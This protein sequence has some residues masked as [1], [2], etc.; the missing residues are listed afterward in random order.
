MFT[1]LK[2]EGDI[3]VVWSRVF[4]HSEISSTKDGSLILVA[5]TT[6]IVFPKLI[7]VFDID[8]HTVLR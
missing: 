2:Y 5:T 8:S 6:E 1:P 4:L 7:F 3:V